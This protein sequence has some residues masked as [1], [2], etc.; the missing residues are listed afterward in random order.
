MTDANPPPQIFC[1]SKVQAMQS[2]AVS[3]GAQSFI[4]DYLAE[5]ISER[6]IDITRTFDDILIIG[7]LAVYGQRL[8][9]NRTGTITTA[10]TNADAAQKA[11]SILI[12]ED[13]LPFA[14]QSFDLV[15]CSGA[16]DITNDLPGALIQI[17]R[18]LRPDGL[19]LSS[20][21]GEGNLATLKSA[22]IRAE[23]HRISPHIHPQIDIRSAA[24][25]LSRAGFALPVADRDIMQ[26]RYSSIYRLLNDIRDMGTGN[27]LTSKRHYFGKAAFHALLDL[28]NSLIDEDGKVTENI[29]FNHLSGWA[30]SDAQPKPAARGSAT[31][32]LASALK[33]K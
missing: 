32:S 10:M 24:D 29:V 11:G 5:E 18:C 8:L 13:R 21:F 31:V 33:A 6:L 3:R 26:V 22:F 14:P 30:P 17:R 27:A 28:W 25:L 19:F 16:L 7:P 9:N 23:T 12:S 4:W 1:E 20:L 15:I 2:R